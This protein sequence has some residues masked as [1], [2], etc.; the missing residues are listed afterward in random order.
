MKDYETVVLDGSGSDNDSDTNNN[1]NNNNQQDTYNGVIIDDSNNHHRMITG[2]G[3]RCPMLMNN[4]NLSL[5]NTNTIEL[6]I[7]TNNNNNGNEQ[8]TYKTFLKLH[9]LNHNITYSNIIGS[10]LASFLSICFF[11]FINVAQP[12]IITNIFH[13]DQDNQGAISGDLTFYNEI[14]ILATS[15][16]WGLLS[17]RFGRRIVYCMGMLLM[18]AGL[19]IYPFAEVYY[20]LVLFRAVFALGAAAAS[21]MISAVLG[22]YVVFEDRP[23]ASGLL[24]L[25]AGFGA[26]FGS[27]ALLKMPDFLEQSASMSVTTATQVTY[28]TTAA[29]ALVGAIALWFTLQPK[30]TICNINTVID[31][32]ISSYG[33]PLFTEHVKHIYGLAREGILA[34]RNPILSVAYGSGFLARGDSAIATTF[35]SLWIYSYD[36]NVNGGNKAAA[37][38]KSG[39]ITGIAQTCGLVFAP[40]AGLLASK[41]GRLRAM[42]LIAAFGALGYF[43]L[44]FSDSPLTPLFLVASCIIGCTETGMVVSSTALVAQESPA[45]CR[46]SVGGIFSLFGAVGILVAAK[47]GG[48]WYDHWNG[49]PFALFGGFSIILVIWGIVVEI[50]V[51]IK[52]N[53]GE[54]IPNDSSSLVEEDQDQNPLLSKLK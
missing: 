1:N 17:D 12:I 35:L 10:Y 50:Y 33:Q 38:A 52:K 16:M 46:G 26:V 41:I 25:S 24:G 19:V 37:L 34:A 22:D 13:L 43:I 6:N 4:S 30:A 20:Q 49:F 54:K 5:S 18:G 42:V 29:M 32:G 15:H 40:I 7:N 21:S 2:G 45:N 48:I 51:T 44:A 8:P 9:R 53:R 27:L 11:V 31:R 23:F 14:V 3:G 47:I 36:L 28:A 39:T